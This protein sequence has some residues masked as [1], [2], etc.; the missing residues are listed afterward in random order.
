MKKK[1][2]N[3]AG[4]FVRNNTIHVQGSINGRFY[5][6]STKKP[7]TR[8]NI[9]W[10]K[11]NAQD[12]LSKLVGMPSEP[13]EE[14]LFED[15][16]LLSLES[17]AMDRKESTNRKYFGDFQRHI[18]PHFQGWKLYEIRPM[19]LKM[20]QVK[21]L[22][23]GLSGKY[24]M[25]I[26][27]VFRGIL[28]DAFVNEIIDKNPFDRV[29]APRIVKPEINSFSLEEVQ[30]L[31]N[32]AQG[33]FK[34]YLTTAF[35]TGMRIGELLALKWEDVNWEKEYISISRAV[36][37]GTISTPKTEN[38]VRIV[39]MLPIVSKA[40]KA[41]YLLTGLE[42]SYI[43][44]NQYG[45]NFT[46]YEKIVRYHWKPLLRSCGLNYRVLYQTRHTFAS[47]MLQQGEEIPWV[48]AMMGHKDIHTTLT[49]YS[50]YIPRERRKRA[51]FIENLDLKVG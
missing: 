19:D 6:I 41:Q 3:K 20:W 35:F 51:G 23:S 48:S 42:N 32:R 29:K 16:A 12:V 5:R 26:R 49:R 8:A 2:Y 34:H 43:F 4:Y 13:N 44:L 11:R 36:S 17:S 37:R 28:Q 15:F 39:D 21:L 40:M 30:I 38:S 33:W 45:K 1:Q 46:Q 22:K 9:A 31:I 14:I 24:V 25:N 27:H 10:V 18:L 50:R 47:I 7:A